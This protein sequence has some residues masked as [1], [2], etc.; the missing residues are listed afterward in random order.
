MFTPVRAWAE[1]PSLPEFGPT[2]PPIGFVRFCTAE[3]DECQ[4]AQ[5][6]EDA[7]WYEVQMSEKIWKA[8]NEVN[9]KVNRDILPM[10]DQELYGKPEHWTYPTTAGDCEDYLLLKKRMLQ[11]RGFEPQKMRIAVVLQEQD[12]GHAV[13]VVRTNEGDYVLDSRRNEILLWHETGY[14]FLKWQSAEDPKVWL[15]L[16]DEPSS[17]YDIVSN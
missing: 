1:N 11:Q 12:K 8:Y 14:R 7:H 3:S 2:L 5:K 16:V 15:S 10:S 6:K 13:L 17:L 4:P 9:T